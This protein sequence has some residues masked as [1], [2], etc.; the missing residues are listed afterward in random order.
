MNMGKLA[1]GRKYDWKRAESRSIGALY[2][3][4]RHL[5]TILKAVKIPVGF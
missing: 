3:L 4:P 5:V 1:G 2:S